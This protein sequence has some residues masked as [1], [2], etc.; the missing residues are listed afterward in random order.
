MEGRNYEY[1]GREEDGTEEAEWRK[2]CRTAR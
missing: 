1:G 2:E